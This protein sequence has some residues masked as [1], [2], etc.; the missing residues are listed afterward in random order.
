ME[1]QTGKHNKKEKRKK[2]N[3]KDATFGT[4]TMHTFEDQV[5]NRKKSTELNRNIPRT[6]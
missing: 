6:A 4:T 3:K 2:K 5:Q 1:K